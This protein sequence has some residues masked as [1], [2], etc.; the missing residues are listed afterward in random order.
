MIN[1][2]NEYQKA[3]QAKNTVKQEFIIQLQKLFLKAKDKPPNDF[4]PE[5][6]LLLGIIQNIP[7]I[8]SQE[9]D[10]LIISLNRKNEVPSDG[11]EF[12]KAS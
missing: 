5:A 10:S 8:N 2:Q 12:L 11:K 7:Y 3:I 9:F 1:L 4:S 6:Q